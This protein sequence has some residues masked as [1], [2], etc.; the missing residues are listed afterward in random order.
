MFNH[1]IYERYIQAISS[2][3]RRYGQQAK[4]YKNSPEIKT[5]KAE[6]EFD[7]KNNFDTRDDTICEVSNMRLLRTSDQ[8]C[9]VYGFHN[10]F[11]SIN[12]VT[13][14]IVATGI[15]NEYGRVHILIVNK[16]L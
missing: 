9:D 3:P 13:I 11:K 12:D 8:S 10:N 16:P 15:C 1:Y 7:S 4:R 5:D 6:P 2:G 14:V